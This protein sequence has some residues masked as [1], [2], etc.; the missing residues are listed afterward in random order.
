MVVVVVVAVA[1][2]A[3]AVDMESRRFPFIALGHK[4]TVGAEARAVRERRTHVVLNSHQ[5]SSE[6]PGPPSQFF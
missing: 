6:P 4:V 3:V 5:L 2:A 1:V